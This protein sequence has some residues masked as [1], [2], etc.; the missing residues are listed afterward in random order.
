MNDASHQSKRPVETLPGIELRE[1]PALT[2]GAARSKLENIELYLQQ[3]EG[4][5]GQGILFEDCLKRFYELAA[6]QLP[7]WV[8]DRRLFADG[9]ATPLSDVIGAISAELA[10]WQRHGIVTSQIEPLAEFSASLSELQQGILD[11]EDLDDGLRR[12]IER[13][14]AG[15][16]QA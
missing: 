7:E 4:G 8:I 12:R 1:K 15:S 11:D 5:A 10:A 13:S 14:I 6:P 9:E 3:T 16:R 2:C